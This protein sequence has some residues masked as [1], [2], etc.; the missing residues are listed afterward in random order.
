VA[1][2]SRGKA[3]ETGR[4]FVRFLQGDTA[5]RIFERYG[6]IVLSGKPTP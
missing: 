5:R 6:F 2:L 4:A 3:S 1:A